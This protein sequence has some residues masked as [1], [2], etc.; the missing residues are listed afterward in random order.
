M[1]WSFPGGR[2]EH[3]SAELF[4]RASLQ[5]KVVSVMKE[6]CREA[7]EGGSANSAAKER[8]FDLVWH[9]LVL[10]HSAELSPRAICSPNPLIDFSAYGEHGRIYN[11]QKAMG[12]L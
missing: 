8:P 6:K 9:L 2:A 12:S 7:R 5:S 1:V 11:A 10:P 4:L 3:E